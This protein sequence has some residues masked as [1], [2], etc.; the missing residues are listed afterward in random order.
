MF[1]GNVKKKPTYLGGILKLIFK[2]TEYTP[3]D[4]GAVT[5]P[6]EPLIVIQTPESGN[7]P[8]RILDKSWQEIHDKFVAGYPVYVKYTDDFE[9]HPCFYMTVVGVTKNYEYTIDTSNGWTW[10][11][12]SADETPIYTFPG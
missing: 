11:A 3:D 7:P 2:G 6:F 5:V 4:S 1:M 12:L 9:P 10:M 8:I